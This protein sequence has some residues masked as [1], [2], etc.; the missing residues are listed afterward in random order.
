MTKCGS[1]RYNFFQPVLHLAEKSSETRPDGTYRVQRRY[2]V[3]R[4][5]FDRLGTTGVLLPAHQHQLVALRDQTNPRQL[6]REIQAGLERLWALPKATPGRTE[7]VH[8]T[9]RPQ[10]PAE[11]GP[12]NPLRC[13]FHR[14]PIREP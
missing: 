2:D 5:P 4:T 6:R 9:L 3:A 1:R 13:A 7:D 10:T 12:D 8:Q 14:T 11:M